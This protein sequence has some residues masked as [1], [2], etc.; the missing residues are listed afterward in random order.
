MVGVPPL[1][2]AH[3]AAAGERLNPVTRV[4]QLMQNMVKKIEKDG[5]AE[6][7]LFDAYVC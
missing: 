4:A 2:A 1:A 6:E 5:K 7:D 3:A